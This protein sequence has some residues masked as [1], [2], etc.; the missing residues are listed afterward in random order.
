MKQFEKNCEVVIGELRKI[1]IK[2][3]SRQTVRNSAEKR[4]D[5]SALSSTVIR[6]TAGDR[7]YLAAHIN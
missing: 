1:G 2:K 5:S 3:I 4:R 7:F 6:L